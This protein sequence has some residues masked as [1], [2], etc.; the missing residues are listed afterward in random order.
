MRRLYAF[1]ILT[2]IVALPWMIPSVNATGMLVGQIIGEDL[3]YR[4]IPLMWANITIYTN[5]TLAYR[6]SPAFD[7]SYSI[8]LAPGLYAV[9]VEHYGFIAQSRVVQIF[10]GRSTQLNFYLDRV[11]PTTTN[12]FDFAISS[13]GSMMVAAGESTWTTIQVSLRSGSPQKVTLSI[14]GLPSGVPATLSLPY[15][16]PSFTSIC[17]IMTS[18]VTP[19]GSYAVTL[20][21]MGGGVTHS[22]MFTLV[23]RGRA[24]SFDMP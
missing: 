22:V 16:S 14:S 6:V 2:S 9:A 17:T 19:V 5:G 7:G 21:G 3:Y 10:N 15:G 4:T 8:V 18:P 23:V 20:V 12:A 1:L 24:Y 13:G 11:P